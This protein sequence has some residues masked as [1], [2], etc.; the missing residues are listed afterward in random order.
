M[1]VVEARQGTHPIRTEARTVTVAVSPAV[2]ASSPV[3]VYL[4]S[5]LR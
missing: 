3:E 5:S 1:Y 4:G 2:L